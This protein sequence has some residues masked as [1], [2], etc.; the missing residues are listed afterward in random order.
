MTAHRDDR[1][2]PVTRWVASYIIPFPAAAFLVLDGLP[3]RTTEFFAWTI[4]PE[5]TPL[6]MGAGDGTGAYFS[7]RVARA[8]EWHRVVPVFLGIATF[9]WFMAVATALHWANFNHDHECST[10][11]C[12]STRSRPC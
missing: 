6:V 12:S 5:M 10:S 11:G 2:L 4:R 1:V 7:Y 3:D 8:D 9:T